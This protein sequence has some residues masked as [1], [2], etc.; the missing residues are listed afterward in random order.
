[1]EEKQTDSIDGE[2]EETIV[3]PRF[4]DEE[5]VL[6]RPVVPLEE[7]GAP[8]ASQPS[9]TRPPLHARLRA[10]PRRSLVALVLISALAGGVLGG[11]GLYMYQQHKDSDEAPAATQPQASDAPAPQPTAQPATQAPA[12]PPAAQPRPQA[13]EPTAAE[14]T[15]PHEAVA[16]A[17]P[18]ENVRANARRDDSA[19][20]EPPAAATHEH[21]RGR[22]GDRDEEIQRASRHRARDE[23]ERS[24]RDA[25]DD[26]EAP[27]AR[28]V[29]TITY[30]PRRARARRDNY[31]DA[32]RLRRIFEGQP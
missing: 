7:V 16:E 10:A 25:D 26:G 13:S 3:A 18:V 20:E 1:M 11:A 19:E 17:K 5:T 29:G 2:G 14:E 4:D 31:G 24:A 28:R 21:E 15:R 8:L 6:A 27:V 22:K 12:A 23:D 32:D 9:A 30:R